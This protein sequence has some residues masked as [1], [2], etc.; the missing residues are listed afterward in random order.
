MGG[1]IY[2]VCVCLCG[3]GTERKNETERELCTLTIINTE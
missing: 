1:C 3:G 2:D